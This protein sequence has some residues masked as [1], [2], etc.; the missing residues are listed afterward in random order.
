VENPKG[1]KQSENLGVDGK[2]MLKYSEKSGCEGV[3]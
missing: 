2:M 1:R 3:E